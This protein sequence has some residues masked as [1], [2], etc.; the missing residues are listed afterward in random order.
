[1]TL[2]N[3]ILV[4]K[5]KLN[6]TGV[7]PWLLALTPVG[8]ATVRFTTNTEPIVYGGQT[9]NPLR[10]KIEPI[11]RTTDGSLQVF[12][13]I[14]TDVGRVL[15]GT[16]RAYNGLRRAS[17]TLTQVNT[18]LLAEDFSED[19]VTYQVGHCQNQ[20]TDIILYCGVPGSIKV[21]VPEDM[22]FCL[23]CRHDFR[24]PS[25]E[26]SSRCGYVGRTISAIGLP[27]LNPVIITVTA[28][29][30]VTGD[31]VRIY[32]TGQIPGLAGDYTIT[33]TGADTFTLNGTSGSDCSGSYTTGGKA[34][35]A[36]CPRMLTRCRNNY[37]RNTSYGGIA[38]T[39]SDTVRLAF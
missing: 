14:V 1:V 31:E 10:F 7:W 21:T 32:G 8:G 16:L 6:Q 9:Y 2:S 24:I 35:Y 27:P 15:Q 34:G 4:E 37:G 13:I 30:Y 38:A 12:K 11:E 26:Y 28:H 5:N 19:S 17:V 36:G 29:P 20:Y 23:E 25:G 18:N 33:K 39:R 22:Y 3:A